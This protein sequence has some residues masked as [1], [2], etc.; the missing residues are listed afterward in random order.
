MQ[1]LRAGT[2]AAGRCARPA[3]GSLP[4]AV[5]VAHRYDAACHASPIPTRQPQQP[6]PAAV[7]RVRAAAAALELEA[8]PPSAVEAVEADAP[9]A[10]ALTSLEVYP[11]LPSSLDA[12]PMG[13][14]LYRSGEA[15]LRVWAPHVERAT[16]QTRDGTTFAL[17]RAGDTW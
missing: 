6:L 9:T 2:A 17:Q 14:T 7:R 16:V 15:S 8:A 5:Q 13:V 4:R 11:D 3:A 10:E 1:A 12:L